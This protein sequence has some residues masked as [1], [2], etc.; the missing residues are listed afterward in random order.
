MESIYTELA[1]YGSKNE[2]ARTDTVFLPISK[3]CNGMVSLGEVYMFSYV[4][5]PCECCTGVCFWI[6]VYRCC[7]KNPFGFYV[8]HQYVL[9]PDPYSLFHNHNYH[10]CDFLPLFPLSTLQYPDPPPLIHT[11]PV[12]YQA[13][14]MDS[15][16]FCVCLHPHWF[17]RIDFICR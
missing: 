10:R 6:L 7:M 3:V 8:P 16:T 13:H 12:W 1:L 9:L 17:Q 2:G 5:L 4:Y 14:Y 15:Y 11:P